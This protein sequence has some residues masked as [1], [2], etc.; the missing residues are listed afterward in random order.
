MSGLRIDTC[1]EQFK[2]MSC[3]DEGRDL[4]VTAPLNYGQAAERESPVSHQRPTPP[5]ARDMH[6]SVLKGNQGRAPQHLL[7]SPP[8]SHSPGGPLSPP[9]I[10][11]LQARTPKTVNQ[12][13]GT[14]TCPELGPQ[15][16]LFT[17]A[18]V[19]RRTLQTRDSI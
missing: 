16:K 14:S 9:L 18:S 1:V 2:D 5:A 11:A 6:A 17:F 8:A 10:T 4:S 13:T 19:F 7:H 3:P 15:T 12:G